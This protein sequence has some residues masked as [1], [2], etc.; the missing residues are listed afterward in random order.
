MNFRHGLIVFAAFAAVPAQ[1]QAAS[2]WL[3]A[4][5]STCVRPVSGGPGWTFSSGVTGTSNDEVICPYQDQNDLK[6][7]GLEALNVY[8]YDAA[9]NGEAEVQLCRRSYNSSSGSCGP[10]TGTGT[11]FKGYKSVGIQSGLSKSAWQNT[12]G[13]AYIYTS[14]EGLG[15]FQFRGYYA[16]NEIN[17]FPKRTFRGQASLCTPETSYDFHD[18]LL[19]STSTFDDGYFVG[20]DPLHGTGINMICSY[21]ERNGLQRDDLSKLRLYASDRSAGDTVGVQLCRRSYLSG[22]G[23]CGSVEEDD[24]SNITFTESELDRSAWNNTTGTAYVQVHL[25]EITGSGQRSSFRG[26]YMETL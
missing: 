25:P 14:Q 4:N 17:A 9:T 7:T 21:P 11:H 19:L 20:G 1:A 6:R 22:G 2:A 10:G 23:D 26:F 18:N 13:V 24:A 12:S 3:R 15:S 5:A 16:K 8:L